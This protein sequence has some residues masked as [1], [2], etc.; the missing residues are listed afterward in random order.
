MNRA[1]VIRLMLEA[2]PEML[3]NINEHAEGME[4]FT[5]EDPTLLQFWPFKNYV[6]FAALVAA[7][8]REACAKVCESRFMGDM[9]RED[10][11]ARRCAAAIRAR[12]EMP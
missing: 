6:K 12:G 1:D 5:G 7:A 11:E 4:G 9:T 8:E 2:E 10:M 3:I